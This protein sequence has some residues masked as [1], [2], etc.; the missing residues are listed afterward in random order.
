MTNALLNEKKK[1]LEE[2][3]NNKDRELTDVKVTGLF[4]LWQIGKYF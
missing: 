3:L 1:Q 4:S 2:R